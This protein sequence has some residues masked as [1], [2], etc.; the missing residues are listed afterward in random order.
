MSRLGGL[1]TITR[2]GNHSFSS[3]F[4]GVG[5]RRYQKESS[6]IFNAFCSKNKT[7]ISLQSIVGLS[8]F[9]PGIFLC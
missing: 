5:E 2:K 6:A 9:K 7:K 1:T 3:C 4:S 8:S